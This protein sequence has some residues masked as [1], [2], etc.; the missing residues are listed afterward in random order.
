MYYPI[1]DKL[2]DLMR[3]I[4]KLQHGTY[5]TTAVSVAAGAE[6]RFD[7]TFPEEFSSVPNVFLTPYND[8][9]VLQS[10]NVST[11]GFTGWARNVT[12]SAQS[13]FAVDW[14]AVE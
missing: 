3:S 10:Q 13:F 12:G 7:V 9:F 14:L 4:P 11:T 6:Q 8:V 2:K 1:I 5:R